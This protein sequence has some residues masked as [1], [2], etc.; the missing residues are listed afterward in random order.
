MQKRE[1]VETRTQS[2]SNKNK[3]K[4]S[5][6]INNDTFDLRCT[7]NYKQEVML[8]EAPKCCRNATLNEMCEAYV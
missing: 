5:H 4:E 8:S 3:A 6:R 2:E 1:F 7:N